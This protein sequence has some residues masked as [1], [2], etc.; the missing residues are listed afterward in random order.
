MPTIT[1]IAIPLLFR[2]SSKGRRDDDA[3]VCECEFFGVRTTNKHQHFGDEMR[4][5]QF[6]VTFFLLLVAFSSRAAE[7][8]HFHP[9]THRQFD[10]H[11]STLWSALRKCCCFFVRSESV[12]L[13]GDKGKKLL[14]LLIRVEMCGK[15]RI[16]IVFGSNVTFGCMVCAVF[17]PS[18]EEERKSQNGCGIFSLGSNFQF[19]SAMKNNPKI[20][21]IFSHNIEFSPEVF[22]PD[23]LQ[24]AMCAYRIF[25]FC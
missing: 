18:R 11:F 14:L 13:D 15:W 24:Y 16:Y 17:S 6:S 1:I 19:K 8:S 25:S 5:K 10:F 3:R 22:H 9:Q 2:S 4:E 7:F 23:F 12:S 21:A 20:G